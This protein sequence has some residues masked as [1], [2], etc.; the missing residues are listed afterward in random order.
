VDSRGSNRG[1]GLKVGQHS[2]DRFMEEGRPVGYH[3]CM[4][5]YVGVDSTLFICELVDL[6][7]LVLSGILHDVPSDLLR[8]ESDDSGRHT[9]R[10]T[11]GG[12]DKA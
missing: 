9:A 7:V 4:H 2:G 10:H 6:L 11:R 1:G 8:G 3:R 12:N 5:E